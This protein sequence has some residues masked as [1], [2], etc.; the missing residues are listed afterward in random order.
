MLNKSFMLRS[1]MGAAATLL[2]SASA[3]ALDTAD[4]VVLAN[5]GNAK[6]QYN[7]GARYAS[8][9]GVDKNLENAVAWFSKAAEQGIAQA[10]YNI[11]LSYAKGLGVE[12]D[13]TVSQFW[14]KRA[15]AQ[16]VDAATALLTQLEY[17]RKEKV[18]LLE[19]S[20]SFTVDSFSMGYSARGWDEDL[21]LQPLSAIEPLVFASTEDVVSPFKYE[22]SIQM[23]VDDL[24][25]VGT[26]VSP[27]Q[28]GD[29]AERDH[30]LKEAI[31]Y[32]QGRDRARDDV[33]AIELFEASASKGSN[34][35]QYHLSVAYINGQGVERDYIKAYLY[36]VASLENGFSRSQIL[37]ELIEEQL[38]KK[39]LKKA[40]DRA[41]SMLEE[42]Q[43]TSS[44]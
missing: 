15:S 19:P 33:K 20:E 26:V 36:A 3:Y 13:L 1:L 4:L 7:L 12:Q 39:D 25:S 9:K 34:E 21:K 11:G 43:I 14:L 8:G 35:A 29:N 30:L 16:G 44:T 41:A 2:L 24:P 10:Q 28:E 32:K 42:A 6:A 23:S 27:E 22:P 18:R 5:D 40:K 31:S 17:D 38:S 37:K